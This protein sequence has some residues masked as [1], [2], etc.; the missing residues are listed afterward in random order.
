MQDLVQMDIS[1]MDQYVNKGQLLD[2]TPYIESGD[3]K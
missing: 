1:Y 3:S 2:L